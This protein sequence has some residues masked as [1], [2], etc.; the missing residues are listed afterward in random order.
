[1][2]RPLKVLAVILLILASFT[3]VKHLIDGATLLLL[4]VPVLSI[5]TINVMM[6]RS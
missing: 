5:A 6:R 2:S 1:M 3:A 4:W